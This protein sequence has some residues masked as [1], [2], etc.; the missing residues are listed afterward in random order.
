M[1]REKF[2]SVYSSRQ[3]LDNIWVPTFATLMRQ[4]QRRRGRP[5]QEETSSVGG[6]GGERER[7]GAEEIF[8]SCSGPDGRLVGGCEEWGEGSLQST[9][10]IDGTV[11]NYGRMRAASTAVA[12]ESIGC[13]SGLTL[14]GR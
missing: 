8:V 7:G 10:L 12:A 14:H 9:K 5:G 13:K 1:S 4:L 3:G 11:K 6:G 2:G